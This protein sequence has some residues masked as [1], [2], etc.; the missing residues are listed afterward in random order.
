MLARAAPQP[1]VPVRSVSGQFVI[2]DQRA[3][4]SPRSQSIAQDEALLNLEPPFLVVSCE[5]IKQALYA[6]LGA[7]RN[8]SGAIHVTI[9]PGRGSQGVAQIN[10][11]RLGTRWNYRLVLPQQIER[12]QF[13]RTLVQVLLL[14]M[15]NRSAG[16]RSA[17][18]P[19]W[20][21]E[22]FTQHLL[23]SRDVELILPPPTLAI[24]S[25]LVDPQMR[26]R[27]NPDALEQARHILRSRPAP[28]LEELSWPALDQFSREEAEFFQSAAQ[29]FVAE[30]LRLK[31]GP[32]HLRTFVGALPRFYNWQTTFLQV[33]REHFSSQLALE[34]WWTLQAAY[35]V[36]RDHQHLWT[37]EE[38]AQK[39]EALLH[40]PI[41]IRAA[42]AELPARSDVSLQVVIR[43]WDTTRQMATLP[44]KLNDLGHARRRV[45]PQF[46]TLVN[47][48]TAVL[49]E[50]IKQRQRSSATFGNFF[51]LAPT[52]KKVAL[53]TLL[54]LDALDLRRAALSTSPPDAISTNN[55][56]K[57]SAL[58]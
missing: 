57:I 20:L 37:R 41:A 44:G 3:V 26:I 23:A 33:Y 17:E 16:D 12:T 40:T 34:K 55:I 36:G 45:A 25:L 28:T 35:F 22:G 38:S 2:Q 51:T 29:L 46:I 14:E 43:E 9:Q 15:A 48:Y 1:G 10:V 21:S 42:A 39:L 19:L 47:D 50:Y 18:I 54:Q 11:E 31:N 24:G 4:V 30:L 8:W 56:G 49:D 58:R 7:A 27:R 52:I 32:E 6:D 53:Q 5:R 13:I